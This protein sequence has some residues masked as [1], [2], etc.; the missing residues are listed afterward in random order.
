MSSPREVI[1]YLHDILDAT[2]SAVQ[3]VAGEG[4]SPTVGLPGA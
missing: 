2:E 4:F 3:F 1:D